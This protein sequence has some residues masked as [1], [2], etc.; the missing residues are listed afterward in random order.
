VK[1]RLQFEFPGGDPST[2]LDP[3]LAAYYLEQIE[4][5]GKLDPQRQAAQVS[6]YRLSF[7]AGVRLL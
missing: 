7:N 1:E 3:A 5:L 6:G 4:A 2:S